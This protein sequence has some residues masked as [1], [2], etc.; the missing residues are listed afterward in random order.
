MKH[1]KANYLLTYKDNPKEKRVRTITGYAI[2]I[3]FILIFG[4]IIYFAVT[5]GV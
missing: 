3:T 1:P 4:S 2:A 5:H